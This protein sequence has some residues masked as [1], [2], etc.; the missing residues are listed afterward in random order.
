MNKYFT[1]VITLVLVVI[2]VLLLSS[3]SSSPDKICDTMYEYGIAALE[4]CEDYINHNIDGDT[5]VEK[6][7]N[8]LIKTN[9]HYKRELEASGTDDEYFLPYD[10]EYYN[11]YWICSYIESIQH[12]LTAQVK[13]TGTYEDLEDDISKLEEKLK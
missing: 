11:D 7:N 1:K 8:L 9:A 6:I 13:G 12:S 5:A 3:C 10:Y 2:T 4:T